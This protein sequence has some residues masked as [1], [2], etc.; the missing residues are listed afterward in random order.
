MARLVQ[1]SGYIKPGKAGGYLRYIA[2]RERVEKLE[3]SSPATEKQKK[4]IAEL[5]RDC[6]DAADLFEYGTTSLRPRRLTPPRS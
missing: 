4:L 5:L 6:P 3:G 1:K 2:T